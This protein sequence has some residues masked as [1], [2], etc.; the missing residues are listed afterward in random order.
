MAEALKFPSF[1]APPPSRPADVC[2]VFRVVGHR[3]VRLIAVYEGEAQELQFASNSDSYTMQCKQDRESQLSCPCFRSS[4]LHTMAENYKTHAMLP[5]DKRKE[6]ANAMTHLCACS[7][8][9]MPCGCDH[10]TRALCSI[11]FVCR[12]P[13]IVLEHLYMSKLDLSLHTSYASNA[14]ETV[15]THRQQVKLIIW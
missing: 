4:T 14:T 9:N 3:K 10:G 5:P 13:L 1:T 2:H 6:L 7:A 8:K 15:L 11:P 12:R